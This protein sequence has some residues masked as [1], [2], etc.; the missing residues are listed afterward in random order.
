ML[1]PNAVIDDFLSSHDLDYE[2]KNEASYLNT[3]PGVVNQHT[4]F[5]F[6]VGDQKHE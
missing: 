2:K 3:L 4:R 6:E 1:D 5:L